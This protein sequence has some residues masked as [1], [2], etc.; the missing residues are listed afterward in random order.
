MENQPVYVDRAPQPRNWL[1]SVSIFLNLGVLIIFI[2]LLSQMGAIKLAIQGIDTN[3]GAE[4][5][6]YVVLDQDGSVRRIDFVGS[7]K[8][9]KELTEAEKE[10]VCK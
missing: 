5:N 7:L 1:A 10:M 3:L 2:V 6:Q 9:E 4:Q 8:V